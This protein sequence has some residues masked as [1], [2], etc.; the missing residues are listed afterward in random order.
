MKPMARMLSHSTDCPYVAKAM[1][2]SEVSQKVPNQTRM[3]QRSL[4]SWVSMHERL[5]SRHIIDPQQVGHTDE[6]ASH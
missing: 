2:V 5:Y 6:S 4:Y 3:F 1:R